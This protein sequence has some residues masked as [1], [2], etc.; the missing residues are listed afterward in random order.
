M[1]SYVESS[2]T[3]MQNT[4]VYYLVIESATTQICTSNEIVFY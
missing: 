2:L 3:K 1:Y 4:I